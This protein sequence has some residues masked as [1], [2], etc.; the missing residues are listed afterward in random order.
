MQVTSMPYFYNI[1]PPRKKTARTFFFND[2]MVLHLLH[3]SRHLASTST[4]WNFAYVAMLS[5]QRNPC[6][7]CKTAQQ[8]TTRGHLLLFRKVAS[9][10]VLSCAN[11][12]MDGQ[13]DRQ[14]HRQTRRRPW[15]LCI[16]PRLR[17]TW[18]VISYEIKNDVLTNAAKLTSWFWTPAFSSQAAWTR[19]RAR[20]HGY[21]V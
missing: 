21:T 17:L 13:T 15:P 7:D 5:Q 16:S 2:C 14:T 12:A 19:S 4:G 9:G 20:G 10:S 1:S 6:T 3:L 8:C 11:A 18:N